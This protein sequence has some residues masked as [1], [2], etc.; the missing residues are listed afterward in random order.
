[1]A[2][3]KGEPRVAKYVT[4]AEKRQHFQAH[5]NKCVEIIYRQLNKI[6]KTARGRSYLY[7]EEQ[8]SKLALY[9]DTQVIKTSDRLRNK[10]AEKET[11][12]VGE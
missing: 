3:K 7:T 4:D 5:I 11:F 2:R 6:G 12:N 9:L 8:V 10:V 1:M